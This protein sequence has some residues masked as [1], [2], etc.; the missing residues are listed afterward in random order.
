MQRIALLQ[1]HIFRKDYYFE[2]MAPV[3][4]KLS[5]AAFCFFHRL[6]II[7]YCKCNPCFPFVNFILCLSYLTGSSSSFRFKQKIKRKHGDA[8]QGMC[9]SANVFDLLNKN[10]LCMWYYNNETIIWE[11]NNFSTKRARC[12]FHDVSSVYLITTW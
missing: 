7:A 2:E 12:N 6:S 11:I 10:M 1:R 8:V 5:Q 3:G 9:K 4:M